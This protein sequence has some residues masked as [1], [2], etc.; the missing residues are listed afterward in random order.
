MTHSNF[1]VWH[2]QVQ[3]I[4][5]TFCAD[6]TATYTGVDFSVDQPRNM[7]SLH[8]YFETNVPFDVF[9]LSQA[10]LE[11]GKIL[12]AHV[13]GDVARIIRKPKPVL[14]TQYTDPLTWHMMWS[15][16]A[17]QLL[18]AQKSLHHMHRRYA[19]PATFALSVDAESS[20]SAAVQARRGGQG[21]KT[22]LWH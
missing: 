16:T 22:P 21:P 13:Q 3:G 8:L 2:E 6:I 5:F 4:T 9:H 11:A 18:S 15:G 7:G 1:Q 14:I 10:F 19:V 12:H 17:A 20:P